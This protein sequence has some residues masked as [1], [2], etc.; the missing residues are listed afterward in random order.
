[1]PRRCVLH[2]VLFDGVDPNQ[3]PIVALHAAALRLMTQF[4]A[5][6]SAGLAETIS[7]LLEAI[8][9]HAE[10]YRAS[11]GR[12]FYACAAAAWACYRDQLHHEGVRPLH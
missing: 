2:A 10:A 12:D 8:G 7:T 5:Q 4:V 9:R 6:P 3:L 1:M 11:H